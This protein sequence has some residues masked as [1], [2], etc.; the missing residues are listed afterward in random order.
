MAN[1]HERAIAQIERD[2]QGVINRLKTLILEGKGL[3]ESRDIAGSFK[4][5]KQVEGMLPG[6]IQDIQL[7]DKEAEEEQKEATKA[8]KAK[9]DKT[10]K[11]R[12]KKLNIKELRIEVK[13][14]GMLRQLKT[15][16]IRLQS[17]EVNKKDINDINNIMQVITKNLRKLNGFEQKEFNKKELEGAFE[18]VKTPKE[19]REHL[20]GEKNLVLGFNKLIQNLAT[21]L[22]GKDYAKARQEVAIAIQTISLLENLNGK[23]LIILES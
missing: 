19:Y 12:E 8:E 1:E 2:A 3:I 9:G 15:R 13:L 21:S 7:A 4:I 11:K 10:A 6:L 18:S 23:E 16:L 22:E 5:L 17:G 20:L 14:S